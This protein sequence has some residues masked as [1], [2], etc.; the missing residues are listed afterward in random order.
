M[1]KLTPVGEN[2][3]SGGEPNSPTVKQLRLIDLIEKNLGIEFTGTTS[4]EAY[5]FIQEH[6]RRV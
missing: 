1:F 2:H 5:S 3:F 4:K 6:Y